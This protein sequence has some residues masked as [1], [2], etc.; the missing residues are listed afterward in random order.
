M[1]RLG[2]LGSGLRW[3]L[4][5]HLAVGLVA[6]PVLAMVGELHV[7]THLATADRGPA[8]SPPAAERGIDVALHRLQQ[9]VLCCG[10]AV[11]APEILLA[12]AD[13]GRYLPV[14]NADTPT[15]PHAHPIAPFRPPIAG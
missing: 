14:L 7:Q 4:L 5:A 10:Q 11:P 9:L 8:V 13:I 12:V 1:T 3:L 15:Y 6:Q 2:W